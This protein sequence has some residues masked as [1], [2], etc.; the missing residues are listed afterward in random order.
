MTV[1]QYRK[2]REYKDYVTKEA[3]SRVMAAVSK[4]TETGKPTKEIGKDVIEVRDVEKVKLHQV[5]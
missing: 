4:V 1:E 5:N 2:T 3:E